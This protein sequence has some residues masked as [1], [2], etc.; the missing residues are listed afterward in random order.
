MANFDTHGD[1]FT[2]PKPLVSS[3]ESGGITLEDIAP[4][5]EPVPEEELGSAHQDSR[6]KVEDPN[7]VLEVKLEQASMLYSKPSH[8]KC[9]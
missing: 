3:D 5:V 6:V 4:Y 2:M 8:K 1:S 7:N 9:N